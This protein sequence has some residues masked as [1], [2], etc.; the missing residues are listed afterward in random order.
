MIGKQG[1]AATVLSVAVVWVASVG[2]APDTS[3]RH[4]P[5]GAAAPQAGL[6]SATS[7]EAPALKLAA[8]R[9]FKLKNPFPFPVYVKIYGPAPNFPDVVK[10]PAPPAGAVPVPFPNTSMY[11]RLRV[12]G[13]IWSKKFKIKWKSGNITLPSF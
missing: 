5:A 3:A 13:G 7:P 12:S 1:S 6:F 8:N 2:A 4:Q 10:V 11:V 9:T